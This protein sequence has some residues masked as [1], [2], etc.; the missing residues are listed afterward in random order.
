MHCNE[1]KDVVHVLPEN[2]RSEWGPNNRSAKMGIE[3]LTHKEGIIE[4]ELDPVKVLFVY[5]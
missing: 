3:P 5:D 2:T 1:V 4:A